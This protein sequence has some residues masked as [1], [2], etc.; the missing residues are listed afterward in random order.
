[1]CPSVCACREMQP[2]RH[3]SDPSGCRGHGDRVTV[4]RT[5][6]YRVL[7]QAR[8]H[9]VGTAFGVHGANIEDVYAAAP[10]AQLPV[11]VA[12]HEFAAGA[13]ADATARLGGQTGMVVTTSGGGAMNVVAALAESFDSRVPV[14]AVI[15][16]PPTTLTGRGAFQDMLAPPDTIDLLG[17]LRGVTGHCGLVDSATDLDAALTSAFD[18]LDDDRPA[19]LVIPKDIQATPAGDCDIGLRTTPPGLDV[20]AMSAIDALAKRLADAVRHGDRV[21]MWLGEEV[22][23]TRIGPALADLASRLDATVVAAPGGADATDSLHRHAG[24]T[25]VMGHPSAQRAIAESAVCLV[26]GCRMTLTDRAGV[27]DALDDVDVHHI[28]RFPPRRKTPTIPVRSVA[29]AVHRLDDAL[30]A[31]GLQI[32]RPVIAV[33]RDTLRTPAVPGNPYPSLADIMAAIGGALPTGT[34]VFADAGNVGAA[35]VHHLTPLVGGRFGV[36]LGMGGMGYAV[37]AA[38]GTALADT[39]NR[40]V[41]IAGDG[42][43]FMH[44]MEFHTAIEHSAPVTMIVLNNDAHG[45]CVT[46]ENIYFPDTANVNR[47]QHTDIAAGMASMFSGLDVRHPSNA[48]ELGADCAELFT[49]TGPNCLVVECHSD[50]VPPFLP[51]LPKGS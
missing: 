25:G 4:H 23:R 10:E 1:M 2:G 18:C 47:F 49:A 9:G 46:R 30:S 20:A 15:G 34:R 38:I 16:A 45:M 31:L 43:F 21:C 17:M 33:R 8:R 26:I 24:V 12:K 41:V 14:L 50:E 44:G 3:F 29:A 13:M 48:D 39:S 6:A 40:S 22:S 11:V 7:E 36:A 51:F 32:A 19:A 27:D 5:V 37:A 28:G 42:A 35:A